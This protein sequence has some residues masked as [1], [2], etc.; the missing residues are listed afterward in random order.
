MLN[1]TER[2][3]EALMSLIMSLTEILALDWDKHTTAEI[4]RKISY[5]IANSLRI[6]I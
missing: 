6:A 2:L 3:D 5:A 1:I 4:K